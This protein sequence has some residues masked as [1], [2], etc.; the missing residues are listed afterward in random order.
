[1]LENVH[2]I[3]LH[4][5]EATFEVFSVHKGPWLKELA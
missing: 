5:V 2:N 1:M 3:T 4:Q